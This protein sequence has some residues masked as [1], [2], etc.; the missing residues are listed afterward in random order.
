MR[1]GVC[2]LTGL[3]F[4]KSE[5]SRNPFASSVDRIDST[6]GYENGNVRVVLWG[7][8]AAC[9]VWGHAAYEE[10]AWAYFTK[11]FGDLRVPTQ[12]D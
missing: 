10:I 9:N 12:G 7:I 6:K 5:Y 11:K 3:R 4:R 8:N 2:E 1:G